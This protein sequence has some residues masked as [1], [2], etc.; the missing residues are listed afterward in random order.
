VGIK[1]GVTREALAEHIASGTVAEDLIALDARIGDTHLLPSGTCHALGA[2]VL[3]AEVQTPSDTTFRVYDWTAEYNR[4]Q[5]E[6]HIEQALECIDFASA[7]APARLEPG[8]QEGRLVSTEFFT[9]DEVLVNCQI[10]PAAHSGDHP[11]VLMVISGMG[12]VQHSSGG[13]EEVGFRPGS[14]LLLPASIAAECQIAAGPQTRILR[15]TVL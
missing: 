15:A 4:P 1:P 5:R 13:F 14:T 3:V 6:L 10:K 7:P 2:G 9:L 11:V 12:S 8:Q